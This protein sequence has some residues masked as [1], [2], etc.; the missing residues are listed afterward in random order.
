MEKEPWPILF[1]VQKVILFY[2]VLHNGVLHNG[3]SLSA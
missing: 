2:I 3:V 1:K